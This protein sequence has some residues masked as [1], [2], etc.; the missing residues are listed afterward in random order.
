MK[1]LEFPIFK[2]KI[3]SSK[4]FDLTDFDQRQEYFELKAG[5]EIKELREYLKENTFIAY[6]LGKKNSGK[7]TYAKM[8]KEVV[9]K[10]KIEHFSIGDMIRELDKV[11]KD[12]SKKKELISS[13]EKNYRGFLPLEEIIKSLE[14]RSTKTLLPSELILALVKKEIA[15]RGKKAVFIDGF[16]R[17]MDQI[18]YS[19]FFRDLVGYRDDPDVFVLIDV[20][21]AVIDER[22]KYRM[23]CPLCQASRNLKLLPTE[24]IGYDKKEKKFYLIC[25]DSVCGDPDC[26]GERMVQKEGDELGIEPIRERLETDEKLIKQAFSLYGI[27]KVL[28]RNSVPIDKAKDLV[29]DYE[30]TPEYS[31]QKD[32]KS[33]EIKK[34]EKPWQVL[35]DNGVPCYSLMPPPVV[36]SLIKQVTKVLGI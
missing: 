25:D 17:E 9:D 2:T 1:N 20:P 27:P 36:V 10:D 19:L 11:L 13:L 14:K 35:D 32:K 5:K 3:D 28:L 8:F 16:P 24:E 30:I 33:E 6:L 7:G 15:G 22:I 29:D 4:K 23:I 34:N 18:S 21:E 12:K 26:K 31:Y